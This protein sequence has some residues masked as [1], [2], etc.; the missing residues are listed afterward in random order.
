MHSEKMVKYALSAL[1]H[2]FKQFAIARKLNKNGLE[3]HIPFSDF[4][5]QNLIFSPPVYMSSKSL[6]EVFICTF[7]KYADN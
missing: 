4:N 6:C 5:H 3:I 1:F 7:I 2:Y